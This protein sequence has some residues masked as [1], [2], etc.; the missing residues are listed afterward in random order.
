MSPRSSSSRKSK[1]PPPPA[2]VYVA[3]LYVSVAA[4]CI[5]CILLGLEL[6]AYEWKLPT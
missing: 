6:N 1:G 3:L 2:D 4:L 5:G